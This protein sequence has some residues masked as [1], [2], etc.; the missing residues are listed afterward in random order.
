MRL[1]LD[2]NLPRDLK[3]TLRDLGHDVITVAD[4]QLLSQSDPV[5]GAAAKAEG[6]V[7][8]TLVIGFGDLRPLLKSVAFQ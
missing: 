3:L 7:L 8:L 1:K 6:R 4:E 2:E 5:I